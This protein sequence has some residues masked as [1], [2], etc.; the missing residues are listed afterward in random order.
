MSKECR[1]IDPDTVQRAVNLFQTTSPSY[2]M[3]SIIEETINYLNSKEG[4]K[5]ID[6]LILN[7][8]NLKDYFK[9]KNIEFLDCGISRYNKN[10]P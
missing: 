2:P 7:I 8:I 10:F 3:I 5:T 1:D 4:L 9:G 6:E